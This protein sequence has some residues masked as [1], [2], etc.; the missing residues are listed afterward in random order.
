MVAIAA[1]IAVLVGELIILTWKPV[2][3][4][5][6]KQR[7]KE[8]LVLSTYLGGVI[9]RV[10]ALCWPPATAACAVARFDVL[11]V[12]RPSTLLRLSETDQANMW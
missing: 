2:V 11:L 8:T 6:L 7:R 9:V 1:G 5:E 10:I 12:D 4:R 3:T